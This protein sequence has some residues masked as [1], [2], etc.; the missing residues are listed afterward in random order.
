MMVTVG[1][2]I[3]SYGLVGTHLP[4]MG[5]LLNTVSTLDGSYGNEW[6]MVLGNDVI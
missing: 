4:I 5:M 6:V 3:T 2:L 1:F